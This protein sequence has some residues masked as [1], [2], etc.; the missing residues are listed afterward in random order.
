[1][2]NSNNTE[3]SIENKIDSL[4]NTALKPTNKFVDFIEEPAKKEPFFSKLRKRIYTDPTKLSKADNAKEW[5][6]LMG[7]GTIG[8]HLPAL[9]SG[10]VSAPILGA[11]TAGNMAKG[12]MIGP[13]LSGGRDT[14]AKST[15]IPAGVVALTTPAINAIGSHLGLGDEVDFMPEARAGLTG[16][17]GSGMWALRNRKNTNRHYY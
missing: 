11:L 16:A 2:R 8:S 15:L 1:M 14:L 9:A 5:M 12:A 3:S 7:A 17:V 10:E 6:T 4:V 13:L